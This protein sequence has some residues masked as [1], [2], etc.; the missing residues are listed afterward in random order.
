M[1]DEEIGNAAAG[2]RAVNDGLQRTVLDSALDCVIS[3]D[4]RGVVTYLNAS[5]ERTFGYGPG[6]AVGRE[7]ADVIVP[8]AQRDA[9]RRGL[10]H[11][12]ATGEAKILDRRIELVAM[13]ADGS[14]FPVELTVTRI[15][16]PDGPAFVGFVRDIT[17]RVRAERE[18][19]AAR[20]RV[21]E[22]ADA[23]RERVTRDIHDGAQQQ[24]VNTLVNVQLAQQKLS[25]NPDRAQEL[26]EI[27]VAQARAGIENLREL[28][29][30]IHPAILSDQGLEAALVSL[31][32][33]M[34]IP[35]VL[36]I[37][38]P[39]LPTPLEASVYF[40]CSEALTNVAKHA[41]ATAAWVSVTARENRLTVEVRDDGIG[42]AEVGSSGSGLLGLQDR[43]AALDG[44]LELSGYQAGSGTTLTAHIPLP[45]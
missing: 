43:I 5:A 29:A 33:R 14:E 35:V 16:L 17:E 30:G 19:I 3:I 9:H 42:G 13:R 38:V 44:H 39:K 21:I 20:R 18:L 23:A 26:L 27:A 6:E 31:M 36:D 37:A 40:F 28:A 2:K 10:G 11:H 12:L 15:E 41:A 8:P 32:D 7:L 1:P 25:A 45:A 24:F 4:G 22:A 34:T